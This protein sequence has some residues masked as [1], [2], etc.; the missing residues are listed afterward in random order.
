MQTEHQ[1][2]TEQD[3]P[4]DLAQ[5]AKLE[6]EDAKARLGHAAER[7]RDE[8]K[9]AGTTISTLVMDEMDRRAGD[10]GQQLRMLAGRMRGEAPDEAQAGATHLVDQ[11]AGLVEDMSHRLEGQ[12]VRQIGARLDRFGRENPALF[13]LGCLVTGALAG[14]VIVA[15]SDGE[16]SRFGS[17]R[18]GSGRAWSGEEHDAEDPAEEPDLSFAPAR[19]WGGDLTGQDGLGPDDF[20]EGA[21]DDRETGP[22]D[23]PEADRHV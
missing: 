4:V 9:N 16:A 6:M 18:D 15:S 7:V 13:M 22:D 2:F 1:D 20:A 8:A 19:E 17:Q 12:S 21:R 14:R 5:I 23:L 3:D 11:A 10:L